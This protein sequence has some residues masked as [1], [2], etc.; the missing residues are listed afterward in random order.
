MDEILR[1]Q[2]FGALRAQSGGRVVTRFRSQQTGALLGY[3]ALH[4]GRSHPREELIELF[5]PEQEGAS[6]RHC[7]S[8]ALS[9]LRHQL[10]PPGT[11]A[12]AVIVAD[13]LSVELHPNSFRTDVEE[14]EEGLR[15]AAQAST[16][17]ER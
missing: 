3:L 12:G 5:W 8:M 7:L 4:R 14:F 2:L 16:S 13:R 10:E 17:G 6:G 9:S 15:R 1:I 11:P